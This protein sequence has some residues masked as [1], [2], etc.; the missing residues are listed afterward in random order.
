MRKI[1]FTLLVGFAS[2]ILGAS[3]TFVNSQVTIPTSTLKST[4]TTPIPNNPILTS[5]V[6]DLLSSHDHADEQVEIIGYFRGWDLLDEVGSPSPVTRSDWV[7]VD[8]SGA[9]Y[10][11]G[12]MPEGLDPSSPEDTTQLIRLLATVRVLGDQVFLEAQSVELLPEQ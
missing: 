6:G 5:L 4:P 3:C 8:N 2:V 9:T 12:L 1:V 10:V 7:I 11:T